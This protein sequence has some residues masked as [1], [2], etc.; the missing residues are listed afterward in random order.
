[1]NDYETD[2]SDTY[3]DRI[4]QLGEEM[5][6]LQTKNKSLEDALRLYRQGDLTAEEENKKHTKPC[7]YDKSVQCIQYPEDSC[8]CNPCEQCEIYLKVSEELAKRFHETYER[9]A[10]DFGY[11]TR[12]ASAKPWKDVPEDNKQLMIAVCKEILKALQKGE[13]KND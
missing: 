10:P 8:G 13:A 1:M 6:Q 5:Q 7:L 2:T 12:E 11:K 9:L 4:E 3:E